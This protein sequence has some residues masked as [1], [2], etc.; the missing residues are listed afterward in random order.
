[1]THL[2]H[3]PIA[4]QSVTLRWVTLRRRSAQERRGY[5]IWRVG[6]G[7]FFISSA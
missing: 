3:L 6:E 5:L 2:H 4:G 1:M 7:F